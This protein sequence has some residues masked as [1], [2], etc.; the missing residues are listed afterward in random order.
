MLWN[1]I[2]C[3]RS[4]LVERSYPRLSFFLRLHSHLYHPELKCI[5]RDL[6][7]WSNGN[8]I[9]TEVHLF[10][11]S[12]TWDAFISDFGFIQPKSTAASSRIPIGNSIGQAMGLFPSTARE[13]QIKLPPPVQ[14]AV[15]PSPFLIFLSLYI[16][17]FGLNDFCRDVNGV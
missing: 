12:G 7:N 2:V 15:S 1:V 17:D 8:S 10:L 13:S 5:F 16:T 9:S 14:T 4:L 11:D 3:L 6:T